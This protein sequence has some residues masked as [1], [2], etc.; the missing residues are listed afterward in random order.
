MTILETLQSVI[1]DNVFM[2]IATM[3]I[4]GYFT[5]NLASILRFPKVTGYLL[6]GIILGKSGLQ[7]ITDEVLSDLEFVPEFTLGIIAI[8]IGASFSRELIK[9]FKIQL[10]AITVSQALGAFFLAYLGLPFF[11]F[12][13]Y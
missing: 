10:L 6:T 11:W 1:A 4:F 3:L 2:V 12:G 9:H 7:F 8:T 13:P 5:A